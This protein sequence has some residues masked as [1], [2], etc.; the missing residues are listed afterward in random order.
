MN[1]PVIQ[2]LIWCVLACMTPGLTE[3]DPRGTSPTQ[4]AASPQTRLCEQL[5]VKQYAASLRTT[6][7]NGASTTPTTTTH[8]LHYEDKQMLATALA[9]SSLLPF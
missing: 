1:Q 2:Y 7:Q 8:H 9:A 5:H 6:I 3:C 4:R